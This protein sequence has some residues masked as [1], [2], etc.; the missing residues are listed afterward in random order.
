MRIKNKSWSP[1][2]VSLPDGKSINL[3]ARGIDEVS[4]EDFESPEFQRLSKSRA[5]IVLPEESEKPPAAESE[6]EKQEPGRSREESKLGGKP[7]PKEEPKLEEKPKSE[8]EPELEEEPKE[9]EQ[10]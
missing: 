4:S 6:T 1:L 3:P 10:Q 2:V 5:V 8:E 7:K 9:D